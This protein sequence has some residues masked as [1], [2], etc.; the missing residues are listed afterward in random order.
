M[1]FTNVRELKLDTKKV[2]EMA[3]EGEDVVV[4]YRGKPK[5]VIKKLTEDEFEDYVLANHPEIRRDIEEAYKECLEGKATEAQA[6]LKKVRWT[7]EKTK[8]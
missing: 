2:L 5:V 3:G 6:L 1:K 7:L 8:S 4:T